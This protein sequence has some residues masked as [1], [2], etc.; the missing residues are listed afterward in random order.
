[1][2]AAAAAVTAPAPAPTRVRAAAPVVAAPTAAARPAAPAPARAAAP[3]PAPPRVPSRGV[4]GTRPSATSG[5]TGA[6][7]TAAARTW[8]PSSPS[9]TAVR[10]T[11][12][13]TSR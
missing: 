6:S 9:P 3:A 8:S 10:W 2:R 5:S 13:T 11:T 7:W 12:P 1:M 4:P